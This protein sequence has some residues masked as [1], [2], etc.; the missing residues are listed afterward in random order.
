MHAASYDKPVIG[1]VGGIGSGKSLA[2]SML[3][4]IGCAVI[5][6]DR[7]GHELLSR[8]AVRQAL[9]QQFGDGILTADGQVDRRALAK[10]AFADAASHRALNGI[11]H[12]LLRK[13]LASRIAEAKAGDAPAIVVDAALLLDTDWHELCDRIVFVDAPPDQRRR[14]VAETRSWSAEELERRE[15]LQKPLDFKRRIAD[16]ILCNNSSESHLRQQVR[17]MVQQ[18]LRPKQ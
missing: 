18:M 8:P 17:L 7:I 10:A 5:D 4:E 2:A 13:E 9:C 14:R 11:V 1:L 16:H 15:N 3:S 6:A 12:P